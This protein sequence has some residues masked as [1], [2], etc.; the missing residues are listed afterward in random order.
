[1][2][3]HSLLKG[4]VLL[5]FKDGTLVYRHDDSYIIKATEHHLKLSEDDFLALYGDKELFIPEDNSAHIDETKDFDYY[6]YWHR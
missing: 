1:M 4:G 6:A 2:Q 5:C 3:A